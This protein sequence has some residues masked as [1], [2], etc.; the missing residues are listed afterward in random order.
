MTSK[1]GPF[2]ADKRGLQ[3]GVVGRQPSWDSVHALSESMQKMAVRS[4]PTPPAK[5]RRGSQSD[6]SSESAPIVTPVPSKDV[7]SN[8]PDTPKKPIPQAN[9]ASY[10]S[11]PMV[12]GF[13]YRGPVT[14]AAAGKPEEVL[15]VDYNLQPR[16]FIPGAM[17]NSPPTA[18]GPVPRA[19]PTPGPY[20]PPTQGGLPLG[21]AN[22][23]L[24]LNGTPSMG[25]YYNQPLPGAGH[26]G[27]G[28]SS[29]DA[30]VAQDIATQIAITSALQGLNAPLAGQ[31]P[32]PAM[33]PLLAAAAAA[34]YGNP[35]VIP[36]LYANS[37]YG[38]AAAGNSPNPP[39]FYP[40]QENVAAAVASAVAALPPAAFH[41]ALQ[42]VVRA[43]TTENSVSTKQSSVV[44]GK[45]RDHADM[46]SN[47]SSLMARMSYEEFNATPKFVICSLIQAYFLRDPKYKTEICRTFWLSGSCPY[48]KR[49]CFIHTELPTN[50]PAANGQPPNG[51]AEERKD[52]PETS[53]ERSQSTN[54]DSEQQQTSMLTRIKRNEATR[55][56]ASTPS[57]PMGKIAPTKTNDGV[58]SPAS[59]RPT[60]AALRVDT[61]SLEQTV[62]KNSYPYT[63]NPAMPAR[64]LSLA[65][66]LRAGKLSPVPATA[67]A[68]FGRHTAAREEVVGIS[69]QSAQTQRASQPGHLRSVSQT[70][71]TSAIEPN[72]GRISPVGR[73]VHNR[74]DSWGP[75]RLVPA[76]AIEPP[77]HY[78]RKW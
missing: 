48:G 18:N 57:P 15:Q 21:V 17:T 32:P 1:N 76:S 62:P 8:N 42:Q 13:Q 16:H 20:A 3:Y 12:P 10:Q 36:N 33:N 47:V 37:L 67:G 22:T 60:P 28:P 65:T 54:S 27:A 31:P 6:S 44:A 14:P 4:N 59:G 30:K 64:G 40:S 68:D 63:S 70:F 34:A 73:E 25:N 23:H 9:I 19:N 26:A 56:E 77:V 24:S 38:A 49:C 45:R 78:E 69:P 74:A 41:A 66:D 71:A 5:P 29:I 2:L 58:V 55:N 51:Q 11:P 43:R 50:G 39:A 53:H 46:G 61:K 52:I 7:D 75:N 72:G 35:Q